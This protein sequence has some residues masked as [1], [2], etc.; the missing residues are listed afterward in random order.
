MQPSLDFI[1]QRQFGVRAAQQGGPFACT[2]V[3]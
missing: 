3:G 2:L 1:V